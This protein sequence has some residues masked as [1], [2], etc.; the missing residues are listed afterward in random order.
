MSV[1]DRL[2]IYWQGPVSGGGRQYFGELMQRFLINL[3]LLLIVLGVLFFFSP[4]SRLFDFEPPA[5]EVEI[6]MEPDSVAA[7]DID[8]TGDA[9]P[10]APDAPAEADEGSVAEETPDLDAPSDP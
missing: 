8:A 5:T 3:L 9:E 6:M 10:S 4:L 1:Y 7:E 2:T